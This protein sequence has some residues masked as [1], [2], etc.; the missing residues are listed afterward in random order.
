MSNPVTARHA[1]RQ[2]RQ[3]LIRWF[4]QAMEAMHPD[5]RFAGQVKLHGSQL[6][7]QG[8]SVSLENFRRIWIFGAGKAAGGLAV[9]AARLL[10]DRIAG[11]VVICPDPQKFSAKG[12]V[13][14]RPGQDITS[15][16]HISPQHR[17]PNN[18][19]TSTRIEF[20]KGDHPVPG[21]NSVTSTTRLLQ[22]A[23]QLEPSD[24]VL[25]MITGGASAMLCKPA[26]GITL[27]QKQ[28][29]HSDL[30]RS[31]ASIHDMNTVRKYLSAVKGGKLL[32]A[33]NGA[34][35][36]NFLISDV[37]G[38]D[39]KTIGSGPTNPDDV[40]TARVRD[41]FS[42]YLPDTDFPQ[43]DNTSVPD[44]KQNSTGVAS[45]EF[46][47]AANKTGNDSQADVG[48]SPK[49]PGENPSESHK[50]P[51]R[52]IWMATPSQN[53]NYIAELA[54]YNGY[55]P[56]VADSPCEGPIGQV[57]EQI[58]S[59]ILKQLK[60]GEPDAAIFQPVLLIYYGESEVKVTG[61]G[62]GGRNQH[63]ALLLAARLEQI[64]LSHPQ[65]KITTLSAGTDGGDGNTEAAG[66]ICTELTAFLARNRELK[67]RNYIKN[68]DSHTFFCELG[69]IFHSGPTG[70]NLMD[71]QLVIIS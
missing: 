22:A 45:A 62:K 3:L 4:N 19:A 2:E 54:R 5:V 17:T 7:W 39:P 65:R 33:F 12:S 13:M 20:L 10:D 9:A 31:G 1:E 30:L 47:K 46:H 51:F 44:R 63:L 29:I 8:G 41:I 14:S 68:F 55:T 42:R 66:A 37:P 36:L 34:T 57:V 48:F 15:D 11:G 49:F 24:L 59:D 25:F 26:A 53:A 56:Y 28:R 64:R 67:L 69:D 43:I 18:Q 60:S 21:I 16:S 52:N 40:N 23:M 50:S 35:V 38:D 70:N 71:L 61:G 32:S 58:F 6:V 27:E